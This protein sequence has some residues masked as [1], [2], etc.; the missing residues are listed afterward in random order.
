MGEADQKLQGCIEETESSGFREMAR[1][2]AFSLTE[3]LVEVIVTLLRP[4]PHRVPRRVPYFSLINLPNT[5]HTTLVHSLRPCPCQL[6]GPPKQFPVAFHTNDIL[7]HTVKKETARCVFFSLNPT[8]SPK[9]SL[10]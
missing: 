9:L 10:V 1:G 5:I 3:V 8:L 6:L 4:S 7:I 2:A